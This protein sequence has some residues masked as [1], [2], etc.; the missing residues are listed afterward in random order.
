MRWQRVV[1]A[2]QKDGIHNWLREHF[3]PRN[4][5]QAPEKPV[6]KLIK[7]VKPARA[8]KPAKPAK[9]APKSAAK[10]HSRVK[11]KSA[12]PA[13]RVKATVHKTKSVKVKAKTRAAAA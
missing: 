13:G 10:T 12:A 4:L 11:P 2:T 1:N 5:E 9:P 3:P 7:A 6:V 8:S